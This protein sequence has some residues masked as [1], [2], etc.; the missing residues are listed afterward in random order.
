MQFGTG[1][2]R[3]RQRRRSC[4]A[5]RGAIAISTAY[6]VIHQVNDAAKVQNHG[7]P[8]RATAANVGAAVAACGVAA[9]VAAACTQQQHCPIA[10]VYGQPR[11]K[12]AQILRL[13]VDVVCA[14]GISGRG[15]MSARRLTPPAARRCRPSTRRCCT[16]LPRL[17]LAPHSP[18]SVIT[19]PVLLPAVALR[20]SSSS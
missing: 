1:I 12:G 5:A 18:V 14:A 4:R 15:S 13:D 3:L 10:A 6:W 16:L 9:G 17:R 11:L 2:R 8:E 19:S 7:S 20:A